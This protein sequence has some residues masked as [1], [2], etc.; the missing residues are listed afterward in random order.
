M[1][2]LCFK[3]KFFLLRPFAQAFCVVMIFQ[4]YLVVTD[5]A[6]HFE[7]SKNFGSAAGRRAGWHLPRLPGPKAP[8]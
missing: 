8:N 7:L 1:L 6:G 5:S 3:F 4:L 2:M